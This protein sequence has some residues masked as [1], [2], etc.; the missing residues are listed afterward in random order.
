VKNSIIPQSK[1]KLGENFGGFFHQIKVRQQ[2]GRKDSKQTLILTSRRIRL[3]AFLYEATQ[4]FYLF[5]NIQE[6]N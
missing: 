5:L 3:D 1:P 4:N 6:L 2:L